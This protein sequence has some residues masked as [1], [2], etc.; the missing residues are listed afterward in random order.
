MGVVLASRCVGLHSGE[1]PT[2]RPRFPGGGRFPDA[3]LRGESRF[4]DPSAR[5]GPEQRP[6]TP[7]ESSAPETLPHAEPPPTSEGHPP[8][9]RPAR[10][11]PGHNLHSC[12]H[13]RQSRIPER[14]EEKHPVPVRP[15]RSAPGHNLHSCRHL[16]QSRI[17]ER[18][19]EPRAPKNPERPRP[20]R[21]SLARSRSR[22]RL[23]RLQHRSAPG[24]TDG[25]RSGSTFPSGKG[26]KS[27]TIRV[28]AGWLTV[29]SGLVGDSL[30]FVPLRA[31]PVAFLLVLSGEPE[32]P[33]A[34][35]R[36]RRAPSSLRRT[37]T[38][39]VPFRPLEFTPPERNACARPAA[40]WPFSCR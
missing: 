36:W 13:L 39:A 12:R 8:P 18:A 40:E 38:L 20:R 9:V 19:E 2:G 16:R 29:V 33:A 1:R 5:R 22:H 25:G 30:S 26:R 37:F 32:Q 15:A 31:V 7:P 3:R 21:Q 23:L 14:A 28:A 27:L 10:S 6:G 4:L 35:F 17:P 11:A 34:A 24:R